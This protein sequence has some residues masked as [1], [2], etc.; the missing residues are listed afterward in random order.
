MSHSINF[1]SKPSDD[2]DMPWEWQQRMQMQQSKM[3]VPKPTA[4]THPPKPNPTANTPDAQP[5]SKP[6]DDYDEPWEKKQGYLFKTQVPNP[7]G[8]NRS[9]VPLPR[10]NPPP[11]NDNQIYEQPWE[12]AGQPNA[13]QPRAE[14]AFANPHERRFSQP[15]VPSNNGP[16][17]AGRKFSQPV[18]SAPSDD[19]DMPW[20]YKN[21]QQFM[22]PPKPVRLHE[23][24]NSQEI[25]PN[26]P[27]DQQR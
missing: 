4:Q 8:R 19:Y 17:N 21:R 10:Q 9:P 22:G 7:S 25:D 23:I 27:L 1:Y 16:V 20:E 18:P 15:A 14:A 12:A 11:A 3:R 2:Y 6:T 24:A 5:S 13:Q 26:K